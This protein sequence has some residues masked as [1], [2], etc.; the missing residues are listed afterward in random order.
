MWITDYKK[1]SQDTKFRID[2]NRHFVLFVKHGRV[3]S[4]VLH[5]KRVFKTSSNLSTVKNI[6]KII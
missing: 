1:I 4:C 5:G 6:F 3:Y 2:Q